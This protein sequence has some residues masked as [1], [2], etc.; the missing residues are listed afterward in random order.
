[1]RWSLEFGVE[2]PQDRKDEPV[3]SDAWESRRNEWS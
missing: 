1:M 2:V 3:L